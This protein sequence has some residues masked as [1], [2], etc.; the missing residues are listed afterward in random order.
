MAKLVQGIV[1]HQIVN[2]YWYIKDLNFRCV[3]EERTNGE[4]FTI[5]SNALSANMF[6]RILS[7]K[8]YLALLFGGHLDGDQVFSA[9]VGEGLHNSQVLGAAWCSE[10]AGVS[11]EIF[12]RDD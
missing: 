8:C 3:G 9:A 12:R 2:P 5:E 10:D 6:H 4:G 1:D 11:F 7:F